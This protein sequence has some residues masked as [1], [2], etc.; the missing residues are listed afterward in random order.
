MPGVRRTLAALAAAALSLLAASTAQALSVESES[1]SH[2]TGT[3][4]TV[5]ALINTKGAPNGAL[6]QF[7]VVTNPSEFVNELACNALN[8][9]LC[10]KFGVHARALGIL[11]VKGELPAQ[12]ASLDLNRGG[13]LTGVPMTLTPGTTYEY[14]VI[15]EA[16]KPSVDVFE[17]IPPLVMGPVQRFTTP[18]PPIVATDGAKATG[19]RSATVDGNADPEGQE[20]Q[21]HADYAVASEPWCTSAGAEGTPVETAPQELGSGSVMISEI[22]VPLAELIPAS[23]Y[24]AELVASNATGTSHGGQV[25]F[26]TPPESRR[27][28]GHRHKPRRNHSHRRASVS[29]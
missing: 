15:T 7:Q 3:D 6:Y 14:R 27:G 13:G 10:L 21:L 19:P 8:S 4:A 16:D 26:M 12:L 9:S 1:V 17:A 22:G 23:E 29:G 24:C 5:E 20:T 11:F 25:R 2:I 28:H 18:S